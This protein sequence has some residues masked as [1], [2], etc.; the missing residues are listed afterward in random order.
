MSKISG[1]IHDIRYL[2]ELAA[3]KSPIH[4]IHPIVK[5]VVTIVYIWILVSF[6]K[7]NLAGIFP[8]LLYLVAVFILSEVPLRESI[9]KLRIVL[10]ICCFVGLLN[11]MF[12]HKALAVAGWFTITGGMVS[13]L[14]L[15][16]KGFCSVLASYLLIATTGIEKLC[17]ALRLIHVPN[18]LVTQI[19]LT[20][21]YITVLLS[22]ANHIYEAYSLR[23]PKQKGI[24]FK[25]WGTILGQ[26]LF[27]SIDR[28]NALYDSMLIRGYTG[29]FYFRS[30]EK[31][32]IS[33]IVYGVLWICYYY[34][35]RYTALLDK[36]GSFFM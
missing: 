19:M 36:L 25:V 31:F 5:L 16:I 34:V 3:L 6:Q 4:R 20:Y 33:D 8:M 17:F 18:I 9:K 28:A 13:G 29:E 27:R 35:V 15:M 14:T 12:D 22:E 1:A 10:P 24:H 2:D 26:L 21:R 23:A 30:Y 7:Y 11:P 32:R